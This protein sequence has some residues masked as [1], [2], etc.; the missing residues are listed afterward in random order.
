[1]YCENVDPPFLKLEKEF[2]E[3]SHEMLESDVND[4]FRTFSMLEN[5]ILNV[6]QT[7][8]DCF[9]QFQLID[10]KSKMRLV[11]TYYSLDAELCRCE[12][13]TYCRYFVLTC[14]T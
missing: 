2:P 11:E 7:A 14:K 9:S 6:N 4:C 10:T 13:T 1:M 5:V 8:G 12:M 3:Y